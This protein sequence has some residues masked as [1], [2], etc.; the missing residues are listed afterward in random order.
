MLQPVLA[1]GNGKIE[2]EDGCVLGFYPSPFIF[3]V[4]YL[5]ARNESSSI[6]IG[7]GSMINNN[8][9]AIAEHTSI[10]IGE[11]CLI[12]LNV[13]IIDSNFHGLDVHERGQSKP[14]WC[15]PVEIEDCVFI[16]NNVKILKGVKIGFGAVVANGSIVTKSVDPL[17]VVGGNPA[18]VIKRIQ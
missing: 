17:T 14:E 5:E 16:G 11:K 6:T 8:F 12:G 13:E 7:K 15:S 2:A 4:C 9:V 18:R 10:K 1:V 3:G